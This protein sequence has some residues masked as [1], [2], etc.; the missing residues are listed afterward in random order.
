M[1]KALIELIKATRELQYMTFPWK[2][3]EELAPKSTYRILFEAMYTE[4]RYDH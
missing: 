1:R 2:I 4:V 3:E